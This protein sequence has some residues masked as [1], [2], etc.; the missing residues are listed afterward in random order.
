MSYSNKNK[1]GPFVIVGWDGATFDILK[2]LIDNGSM[3]NLARL[4]SKSSWGKLESTIPPLTPPAWTSIMTGVNPG[5]HGIF[6]AILLDTKTM[7]LRFVNATERAA[8]PIWSILS[9]KGKT[10]GAIN[11]PATYPPDKVNGFVIPGMFSSLRAPDFFYP[12]ELKDKLEEKVGR[13]VLEY[14]NDTRDLDAYK[15]A[16]FDIVEF[17]EKAILELMEI[18]P[19]DFLFATFIASDR[20]QHFFWKFMD[21]AHPEHQKHKDAIADVYVKMDHALGSIV[22][23]AGPNSTI[24]MV[25][26]HGAG[27]LNYVF[28]LNQWLVDNGFLYLNKTPVT[29]GLSLRL[30]HIKKITATVL[31]GILPVEWSERLRK[32]TKVLQDRV[33]QKDL[34]FFLSLIDLEKSVAFSEGAG[35]VIYINRRAMNEDDFEIVMQK[36]TAELLKL[37]GPDGNNVVEKVFR[38]D[39]IYEGDKLDE[40]ADL[41]VICN[42]GYQIVSPSEIFYD[43]NTRT[44]ILFTKHRWSGR[45]EKHGIFLLSGPDI[46]KNQELAGCRVIDAAPT[47]LFLMDQEVPDYMDGQV[48]VDA[49]DEERLAKQPISHSRSPGLSNTGGEKFTKDE[50]QE[51]FEKMKDLG[52]ME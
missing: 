17:R 37:K 45:H 5:K 1:T 14:T 47:A 43:I 11:V 42:Q 49:I 20:V 23:K 44:D 51:I 15:K 22:E 52:Y 9:E 35:G 26:D 48:L 31:K 36:I 25:S 13:Y 16:L 41:V 7:K 32:K 24:M 10:V 3:P 34:S 4:M 28:S 8:P 18:Y 19:L 21:P 30:A 39:E 46:K 6:D 2:P 12:Q 50:E 27:P 29:M 40:A 38:T 33:S